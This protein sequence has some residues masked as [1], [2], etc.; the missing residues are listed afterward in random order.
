MDNKIL[1]AGGAGIAIIAVYLY[2]HNQ[3]AS[4]VNNAAQQA[5]AQQAAL[6]QQAGTQSNNYTGAGLTDSTAISAP[7]SSV[8]SSIPASSIAGSTDTNIL[9]SAI[10]AQ[11]SNN[12]ANNTL[13]L[14]LAQIQSANVPILAS[15][16]LASQVLG[17]NSQA[18][19]SVTPTSGGGFSI[20]NVGNNAGFMSPTSTQNTQANINTANQ[21][22]KQSNATLTA[23][24]AGGTPLAASASALL[25][26]RH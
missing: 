1:Y 10:A 16:N 11:T 2:M 26:G 22:S 9:A 6:D 24:A 18:N 23:L 15:E 13:E 5:A 14:Q 20:F 8:A 17:G 12:T 19:F 7:I 4:A 21:L 25:T 3:N